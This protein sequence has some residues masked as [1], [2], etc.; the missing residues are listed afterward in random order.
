MF[1]LQGNA[2]TVTHVMQLVKEYEDSTT[3]VWE[4]PECG[5]RFVWPL[6][7]EQPTV[8]VEANLEPDAHVIHTTVSALQIEIKVK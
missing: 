8:Y 2:K 4:C 5:L 1:N 3:K 7:D 6:G